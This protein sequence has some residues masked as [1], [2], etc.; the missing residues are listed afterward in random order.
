MSVLG[1]SKQPH[2]LSPCCHASSWR[3]HTA[4]AVSQWTSGRCWLLAAL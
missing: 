1:T 3:G 4:V 2:H